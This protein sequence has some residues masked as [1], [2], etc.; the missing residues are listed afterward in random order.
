MKDDT[1]DLKVP[2]GSFSHVKLTRRRFLQSSAAV[3]LSAAVARANTLHDGDEVDLDFQFLGGRKQVQITVLFPSPEGDTYPPTATENPIQW[4]IDAR[5]F[6]PR[7]YFTFRDRSRERNSN[8]VLKSYELRVRNVQYGTVPAANVVFFFEQRTMPDSGAKR[9]GVVIESDVF[10]RNG[11]LP[12]FL[13]DYRN[14]MGVS[15]GE[16]FT[17]RLGSNLGGRRPY[18]G[19]FRAVASGE[20]ELRQVVNA[21]VVPGTFDGMFNG[22]VQ[23]RPTTRAGRDVDVVLTRDLIWEMRSRGAAP[24]PQIY[25]A[26][27]LLP[28][29]RISFGWM[30]D[31]TSMTGKV[32]ESEKADTYQLFARATRTDLAAFD[33]NGGSGPKTY[34]TQNSASERSEPDAPGVFILRRDDTRA[35]GASRA[36][37]T[38]PGMFTLTIGDPDDPDHRTGPFRNL[39]ARLLLRADRTSPASASVFSLSFDGDFASS[40]AQRIVSP[41]GPLILRGP[42]LSPEVDLNADTNPETSRR[43]SVFL[44]PFAPRWDQGVSLIWSRA[45]T[46][47]RDLEWAEV[48]VLLLEHAAGLADAEYS[49]LT[50]KPTDMRILWAPTE[51]EDAAASVKSLLRLGPRGQIPG[52]RIDLSQA[53]LRASRSHDLLSLGFRF[54]GLSLAYGPVGPPELVKDNAACLRPVES[55]A[56]DDD[57]RPLIVV[58]FPGQHLFEEALFLPKPEPLPDVGL[59][60]AHGSVDKMS[61]QLEVLPDDPPRV[62]S[63]T[64]THIALD[65]ND[66][67]Q[68]DEALRRL[69]RGSED[70]GPR[71]VFRS[72]LKD[73][74]HSAG[75]DAFR[76]FVDAFHASFESMSGQLKLP[77]SQSAYIGNVGLDADTRALANNVQ[78]KLREQKAASFFDEFVG[79]LADTRAAIIAAA[80]QAKSKTS[81]DLAIAAPKDSVA[82]ALVLEGRLE[83]AVPVY[84]LLRSYYR[85]RMISQSVLGDGG[86]SASGPLDT[87]AAELELFSA[88]VVGQPADLPPGVS[89]EDAGTRFTETR[90]AFTAEILAHD[91][92]AQIARQ[93]GKGLVEGRLA[94]PSRLA[95]RVLCRDWTEVQRASA[96]THL[97]EPDEAE[98]R[99]PRST[100][101]FSLQALTNFADFE[102]AVTKRAERIYTSDEGGRRDRLSR[103]T[104]NVSPGAMLDHLG[105]HQGPFVNS[106]TRLAD[107]QKALQTPPGAFETAIEIPARLILS[108]HQDAVVIGRGTGVV[109]SSVY[110]EDERQATPGRA[111]WSADFMIE[112]EDPGIRAVASPDLRSDFLWGGVYGTTPV[113]ESKPAHVPAT[114]PPRG[115]LAP[116]L[117]GRGDTA[118]G[119]HE[120]ILIGPGRHVLDRSFGAPD[121]PSHEWSFVVQ[122]KQ[123]KGLRGGIAAICNALV[124]TDAGQEVSEPTRFRGPTDAFIRHELV[125]LSSGWGLPVVGRR[126][127]TGELANG[128]SQVEPEPRHRLVD[129]TQGSALYQPRSLEVSELSLSSLGGSLRHDSSFEPPAAALSAFSGQGLFDALSIE[130]WQ[131]WTV[132]GRDVFCEV[133]FKGFLFPLGHRAALVQVTE[134]EFLRDNASGSIRAY[135]RQRMF[136]R[137]GKPEKRFPAIGQPFE[138]RLFPVERLRILTTQTPDI[139]D[140]ATNADNSTP[141]QGPIM[142][143]AVD[144]FGRLNLRKKSALAFWP[145]TAPLQEANVRFEMEIDGAKADLPLIFVDNVAANDPAS[146]EEVVVTYNAL[147]SPDNAAGQVEVDPLRHLR[148]LQFRGQKRRYAPEKKA[149]SAS[150]ETDHWTLAASGRRG[151]GAEGAPVSIPDVQQIRAFTPSLS[152]FV[153]DPILQGADQPPFYPQVDIARVRLRQAER[154]VGRSYPPVRARFEFTYLQ[155]GFPEVP[156]GEVIQGN[157][158]EVFLAVASQDQQEQS[159][160]KKGDQSG[161]VFRPSG[162]MVGLSRAKG[163]L[164]NA[165]RVAVPL[166]APALQPIPEEPEKKRPVIGAY[167]QLAPLFDHDA[168]PPAA[169]QYTDQ[170]LTE[171]GSDEERDALRKAN[172]ALERAREIYSKLFDS[173]AKILGLVSLKDLMKVLENLEN[174][175]TGAPELDEQIRY[176]AG[177]LKGAIKNAQGQV[178]DVVN[179]VDDAV[180]ELTGEVRQQAADAADLVRL[181]VVKP[182]S[183]AVKDIR[184]GWDEIEAQLAEEQRIVAPAQI[185]AITFR[186]IFPELDGGLTALDLALTDSAN[187]SDQ[188]AFALSLGAV[189]E[190]GRRFIDALQRSLSNPVARIEEAFRSRFDAMRDIFEGLADGL[191]SIV[192][193]YVGTLFKQERRQLA[194]RL[195]SRIVASSGSDN[196][197]FPIVRVPDIDA[198]QAIGLPPEAADKLVADLRAVLL[199]KREEARWLLENFIVFSLDPEVIQQLDGND[200]LGDV[201]RAFLADNS[202]PNVLSSGAGQGRFSFVLGSD[203]HGTQL[204]EW[205]DNKED[206]VKAVFGAAI[207]AVEV[208][209]AEVRAE[210]DTAVGEEQKRLELLLIEL[211]AIAAEYR[212]LLSELVDQAIDELTDWILQEFAEEISVLADIV[213]KVEALSVAIAKGAPRP[214]IDRSLDLIEVFAGPLQITSDDIC[215]EADRF[216]KPLRRVLTYLNPEELLFSDPKAL[217]AP[218]IL[219]DV[220]VP[221]GAAAFRLTMTRLSEGTP[222]PQA[223]RPGTRLFGAQR[224]IAKALEQGAAG[225]AGAV[226]DLQDA[227]DKAPSVEDQI[228]E[229]IDELQELVEPALTDVNTV[230]TALAESYRDLVAADRGA[231]ILRGRLNAVAKIDIC[232]PDIGAQLDAAARLPRDLEAFAANYQTL[233]TTLASSGT[234]IGL[235]LKSLWA[236]DAKYVALT[237]FLV[238]EL[239]EQTGIFALIEQEV[240]DAAQTAKAYAKR[241]QR[242]EYKLTIY[243]AGVLQDFVRPIRAQAVH[244]RALVDEVRELNEN[245]LVIDLG[246]ISNL[247]TNL[248]S[249]EDAIGYLDELNTKL[250]DIAALPDYDEDKPADAQPPMV[251][252]K[253]SELQTVLTEPLDFLTA[254]VSPNP[255]SKTLA[256]FRALQAAIEKELDAIV[257]NLRVRLQRAETQV[258]AE[259]DSVVVEILNKPVKFGHDIFTLADFYRNAVQQRAKLL[260]QTPEVLRPALQSAIVAAPGS[261]HKR[262]PPLPAAA[263]YEPSPPSDD[264]T[265]ENDALAGDSA[266]LDV[267]SSGKPLSDP[268]QRQ[269]L[270]AF[271]RQWVALDEATPVVIGQSVVSVLS[272]ILRGDIMRL[273]DLNAIRTQIEDHLLSLVPSEIQMR[274]GYGVELGDPVRKATGGIFAPQKGTRLDVNTGIV[275]RLNQFEPEIAFSSVGTL[276]AFDVK[277][278]GDAFDALTLRF[279]G[280]RFETKGGSRPRFDITYDDYVIGPQLEFV[281]QLQSILSP[282][283]GSGA[284]IIP[285]FGLPGIEA[286]YSMNLGIFSIGAAS[287]FNI[288]LRTSAILP[289]GDGDA[290]F[291]AS[292]SSRS[293]PFTISYLPFGGSGFFAI[294][295]NAEGIVGFEASFDFGGAAAFGYGPL[296]GQGRLMSGIYVRQMTLARGRKLTEISGTFYV[297]GSARIWIFGF[298]ASLYVRLGMVNGNM[299]GEAVFTYSFSIGIKDFDFSVQVWKQ[300]AK[301]FSGQTAALS[302][303]GLTRFAQAGGARASA[304]SSPLV[305]TDVKAHPNTNYAEYRDTYFRKPLR[306]EDFF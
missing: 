45:Q 247:E 129:V 205:L 55:G 54:S 234:A 120:P 130:R 26:S 178:N 165:T 151:G 103:R 85:D 272:D 89:Q 263:I 292:L 57:P 296:T 226:A 157:A 269:F 92:Q 114:A 34:L 177:Q 187:Q 242:L 289:F 97:D 176:G 181:Q 3:P 163:V 105:F 104:L 283:E 59:D 53:T 127:P 25:I 99:L 276:G 11:R 113:P 14:P 195:A 279:K 69:S 40:K 201:V 184:K 233:A 23:Y 133:T 203:T 152:R 42:T 250:A 128:A 101:K 246:V 190:A 204:G 260:S 82:N 39:A 63:E 9:F 166:S 267:V 31:K 286:G 38:L 52:T 155:Q 220:A 191:E 291:R 238:K 196:F 73:L 10:Q 47:E 32:S 299:S 90:S 173:K 142:P 211:E 30:S 70:S 158:G 294:E 281:Q 290:R 243:I 122:P 56:G 124:G 22:L 61:G 83:Q 109:P 295:A 68:V 29:K 139:M 168:T 16:R 253:L 265:L 141:I 17:V 192:E 232:G 117:S 115:P 254:P 51:R 110:A 132:L 264:P 270:E 144:A 2:S 20:A 71:T 84:Q 164:S 86:E 189:Y 268:D 116:W 207:S 80:Q 50:F 257:R 153:S 100:L 266:W 252:P 198:L 136:I 206:E 21:N 186:E 78:R 188:I 236:G 6:G 180:D 245:G 297:G 7:A 13:E 193:D 48:N 175:N 259:F 261:H 143:V 43:P 302:S 76:A 88:I 44:D 58:D 210:I 271:L 137:L 162:Q 244:A 24:G 182:L 96:I 222:V 66:L 221:E 77:K 131:Q 149:G 237:G 218:V 262:L 5:R 121:D 230:H 199:L 301:G 280:A 306:S 304:R 134:R 64:E 284:F 225:F 194:N 87:S 171:A 93:T 169:R 256:E 4:T 275:I 209:I 223:P 255:D 28:L 35:D 298:G 12:F 156:E 208:R 37:A 102:L 145:R 235:S 75:D 91:E 167:P 107:I 231:V 200:P 15:D 111:V 202:F 41:I 258:L 18:P 170:E 161:G 287:F 273:I 300:E 46:F 65:L 98:A 197:A 108:P 224:G 62:L 106:S 135:L 118:I 213:L 112:A 27:I 159:M 140:P 216:V 74:K 241:L 36:E 19:L 219:E 228:N 214:V 179:D 138:G 277:L 278:V 303:N 126:L 1:D 8:G 150:L 119:A 217:G 249:I 229:V 248:K 172:E 125:L 288:A 154:L 60:P 79:R 215:K 240:A 185:S 94:N 183:D 285:R 33:L 147:V 72:A 293:N 67:V 282:S 95:F 123:K 251:G 174:P 239:D 81:E 160:G 305:E 49:R 212:V 274:Y 227:K 148:T 146:L